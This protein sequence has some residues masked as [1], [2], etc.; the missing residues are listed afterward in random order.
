M[1][2]VVEADPVLDSRRGDPPGL[3]ELRAVL[4]REHIGPLCDGRA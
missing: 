4:I 3:E 1:A 2:E